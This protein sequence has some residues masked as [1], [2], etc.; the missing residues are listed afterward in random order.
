MV[1]TIESREEYEKI[2]SSNKKVVVQWSA[3]WCSHCKAI[4]PKLAQFDHD[5]E[6]ITFIKVDIDDLLD[7]SEEAGLRA[8]PTIHFFHNGEKFDELVGADDTKLLEHIN[9]LAAAPI[10]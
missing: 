2:L 8:M 5:Y 9:N 10:A 1:K 7:V 6:D 3:I 4:A